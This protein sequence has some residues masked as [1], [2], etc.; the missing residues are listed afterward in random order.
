MS[1]RRSITGALLAAAASVGLLGFPSAGVASTYGVYECTAEQGS[2]NDA[3]IEGETTGYTANNTCG[4]SGDGFL[5]MGTSGA[6]GAG[7]SKA[8]VF[9]APNGTRI[10]RATGSFLLQG[11]ADHGGH[12]TFFF[13]RGINQSSDQ[14][15]GWSGAGNTGGSF[16]TDLF[17]GAVSRFGV[18][19]VC[20][21]GG[22]CPN[23]SG[24]YSRI[25][26]LGFAMRDTVAPGL[27]STSGPALDGWV[28]GTKRV[29]FSVVDQGAG[30]FFGAA[31]LNDSLIELESYC[32]PATDPT[33]AATT[34]RPCPANGSGSAILDTAA[35]AA[36][37]GDN[38]LRIC[39]WE[40]GTADLQSGC[41]TDVVRID[42]IAPVAPL[43]LAVAGGEDWKRDNDFDLS[44]TNPTEANAPIVGAELRIT[45][46]D[47]F[48]ETIYEPGADIASIDD[49][50]VPARGEYT[51]TVYL[52]DAAGNEAAANG[53]TVQLRF[54]DTVPV[55]KDPAKANGWIGSKELEGTGYVQAWQRTFPNET[56]P[57]GIAGY[58]VV[59]NTNSDTDPCGGASD[60]RTCGGPITEPGID[61]LSRTLRLGDLA[62]GTNYVHVVPISGSGMRATEVRHTALKADFTDPVTELQGA[63][64]GEWINHDAELVLTADDAL[65]GM[66]DTAEFPLDDPPLAQLTVDGE[67]TSDTPTVRRTVTAEGVHRVSWC[68]RDL[69]GNGTCGSGEGSS[70]DTATVRIDKTAPTAAFTNGQD[71]DDP[72]K[73]VA[74]VSD[75]LS[76]V[77]DGRISYRQAG[78]SQWKAL[79]TSLRD[80]RLVA[81]VDSGDLRPDVTYEFRVEA[82]DAAGNASTSGSKQ[83]GEPMRVTGPFRALTAVADLRIDGRMKARVRYGGR[84][85]VT[86]ELVTAA[87][88]DPIPN[89]AIDLVTTYLPGSRRD[90]AIVTVTT[91]G[92][93]GFSAILPKGPSRSVVA[94]YGGDRRHLGVS[95]AAVRANV[96]CGVTLRVPDRVDSDEGIAFTGRVKAKGARLGRRGKRLAIQVRVGRAWKTVGNVARTNGRGAYEVPYEFTAEYP[97]AVTYAFRAVVLRDADFPYLPSKSKIRRVTVTP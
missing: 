43:D 45:G 94:R 8:W 49:V 82:T 62:E 4:Q 34:M 35:A 5:Q 46:P 41:R 2:V 81:R 56:P 44:W 21:S 66:Q 20:D 86:G 88:G 7:Q 13:Y 60:P 18:G 52:R 74:P 47:G 39:V 78:G 17:G 36:T 80:G 64:A 70:G 71:P 63:A 54:D 61:S 92:Q 67:T 96:R 72:D 10:D 55:P 26:N 30:V 3:A 9:T 58:R 28:N 27:P 42:T 93:G 57:S 89:A 24:V 22:V 77:V 85:R 51:A 33:G 31:Y 68:A 48:E 16:D 73:L 95:S 37:Q 65:S 87:G 25:G 29:D 83:N 59:V 6:V 90:A 19:I 69:A 91:N 14:I 75:A 50:S 38:A 76:G 79:E 40:Y 84:P 32:A 97:R 15:I 12:R 1:R 11:V 53:A 23:R